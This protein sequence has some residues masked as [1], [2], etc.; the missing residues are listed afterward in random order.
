MRG[1]R[2]RVQA[3]GRVH[4]KRKR[5]APRLEAALFYR[6]S[7]LS[8]NAARQPARGSGEGRRHTHACSLAIPSWR[9]TRGRARQ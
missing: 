1:A 6:T 7:A 5:V 4:I 8:S 3:G 2:A 9:P